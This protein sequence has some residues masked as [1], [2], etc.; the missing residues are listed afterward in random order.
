MV[1][2]YVARVGELLAYRAYHFPG[3]GLQ[4]AMY[5][6]WLLRRSIGRSLAEVQAAD[7][8][9]RELMAT[10]PQELMTAV[11]FDHVTELGPAA[12]Q[13]TRQSSPRNLCRNF[14]DGRCQSSP[15]CPSGRYHPACI[16]CGSGTHHTAHH[17]VRQMSINPLSPCRERRERPTNP[18]LA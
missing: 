15:R 1:A 5:M 7:T 6:A 4:L 11:D 12:P 10:R 17:S 16:L 3:I 14:R 18:G 8:K 13:A 2:E 9:A